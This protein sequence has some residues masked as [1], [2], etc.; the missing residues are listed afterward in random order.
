MR[1]RG[2]L[3]IVTKNLANTNSKVDP[4]AGIR[5][6]SYWL[7]LLPIYSN[8]LDTAGVLSSGSMLVCKSVSPCLTKKN[9]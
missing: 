3:E 5:A 4:N 1:D 7:Y 2:Q 9:F 8:S 6:I